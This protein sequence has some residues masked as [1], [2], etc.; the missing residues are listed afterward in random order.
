MDKAKVT[1]SM[2]I[3]FLYPLASSW[4]LGHRAISCLLVNSTPD[5]RSSLLIG[6]NG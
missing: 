2:Q 4:A 5:L 6:S 1:N 3:R